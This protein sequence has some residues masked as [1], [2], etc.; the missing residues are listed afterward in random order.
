MLS[1]IFFII[2][3]A[4]IFGAVLD[5]YFVINPKYHNEH[6]IWSTTYKFINKN[7]LF[8][9]SIIRIIIA[10]ILYIYLFG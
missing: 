7:D 2:I 6:P 10:V 4:L 9:M 1:T 3:I 8:W 5:L